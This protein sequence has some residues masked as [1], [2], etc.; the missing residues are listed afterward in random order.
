MIGT[1]SHLASFVHLPWPPPSADRDT[2]HAAVQR[3]SGIGAVET[4]ESV[5]LG[6]VRKRKG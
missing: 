4:E 1:P 3:N 6:K 5:T 2:R